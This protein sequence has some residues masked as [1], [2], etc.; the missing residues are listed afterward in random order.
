MEKRS[1]SSRIRTYSVA[2]AAGISVALV[3]YLIGLWMSA[4]GMHAEVTLIDEFLLAIFTTAL[5]LV[6]EL[7]HERDQKRLNEK[8]RTIELM[9]HHVRNAL[10]NIIDSAYVHGHLDEV[11][12]S[13]D[14]IG[15]ALREILPGQTSTNE[16][17]L[18]GN[19]SVR[20]TATPSA[21]NESRSAS[22]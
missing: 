6:V 15:W 7:S 14:R 18:R 13:V 17:Q 12:S 21:P 2:A 22:P 5:V 20:S 9:N 1:S 11:R 8:L 16:N 3:D 4:R 19:L 10:Q